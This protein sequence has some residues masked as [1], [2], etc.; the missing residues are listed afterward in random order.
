[1]SVN[2]FP[3]IFVG[4]LLYIFYKFM[5]NQGLL[6][7]HGFGTLVR[8][9]Q[10]D[11]SC[12][13]GQSTAISEL[14]EALDFILDSDKIE[15]MGIRPLKGLLLTGP[16]GTGKTLLAK[17][18]AN[19]TDSVFI[20]TSGSEFI[21]VYAGVGAQR[22]RKLF[23]SARDRAKAENKKSAIIFIDEIDILGARRGTHE[24]HMEYDQTL[25]QLLV[26]M[27]GINADD[28]VKILVLAATNR[29]DMLDP[30]LLRPGRFDRQVKVDLPD[31]EG[32][33]QILKI[34]VKNKPLADDVDLDA[35]ARETFGFSGAHL[36]SLANEAAINA[37]RNKS[38]KITQKDFLQ[39]IDKVILGEKIDKKPSSEELYRI[40]VHE[41]GHAIVS[42]MLERGSVAN[43]T[44]VPRGNAM[45]FLRQSLEEDRYIY[46]REQLEN[47]IMVCLAGSAA[48]KVILGN[49]STGAS[50]DFEKAVE[51]AKEIIFSGLSSLGIISKDD[52]SPKKVNDEVTNIIS[53]LEKKTTELLIDNHFV[54]HKV[55]DVLREKETISGEELRSILNS[56]F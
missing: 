3:L 45:G 46:T 52:I 44:I 26:E 51:L 30:A 15:K 16:P 31:K 32:R 55:V 11:F 17:A 37:M 5:V 28:D 20:A 35:I 27:D 22:V 7:T 23:Q 1:M 25:N 33:L 40:A 50:N 18:A 19:Y 39:A 34:H 4:G 43:L 41:A 42:E 56:S 8:V 13:G 21:E 48:E 10:E 29:P 24:S 2:I 12:I 9:P 54:I 49:K 38:D 14:K 53:R 36:E 47:Q 6:K